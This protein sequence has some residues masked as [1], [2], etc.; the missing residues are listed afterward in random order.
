MKKLFVLLCTLIL[1]LTA[2]ADV[3]FE[4]GK[5]YEVVA[6]TATST[7][8]IKEFFSFYCPHCYQFE[9]ILQRV[10]HT[11]PQDVSVKKMHVDFLRAASPELQEVLARA[12]VVAD[13][14]Q[15]GD[16]IALAIFNHIHRDRATFANPEDIR[17][18]MLVND[19]DAALYDSTLNSFAV[20]AAVKQMKQ[21]QTELANRRVLTGVPMLLVNGKYKI[22]LSELD[23][24]NF[25]QQLQE[26]IS[27]LLAKDA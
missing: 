1:P 11:L 16:K 5:Q 7:P 25:E 26:L 23:K 24:T 19:F 15:Q 17:Q 8:E 12:Y 18:L 22:N 20:T 14:Q 3:K 21:E 9:P 6:T 27:Y 10:E 2:C 13:F 4:E